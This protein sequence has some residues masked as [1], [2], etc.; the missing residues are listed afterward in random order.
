[1]VVEAAAAGLA[2]VASDSVGAAPEL[3]HDERNGYRFPKGNLA[4]L[5]D[6]LRKA[7]S[8][9]WIDPAKL[10]SRIIHREWFATSDP[11]L[12]LRTALELS[13]V[14]SSE[15]E[16]TTANGFSPRHPR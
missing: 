9:E 4:A 3:V 15:S 13:G 2:I 8:P 1:V 11:V 5:E 16:S 7:T 6:A 14:L 12:G 10:Q